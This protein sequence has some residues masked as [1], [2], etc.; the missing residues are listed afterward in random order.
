MG[1]IHAAAI[2]LAAGSGKRMQTEVPKQFLNLNG[3]PLLYYSLKIF[4]ESC[5]DRIVLVTG[6]DQIAYCRTEI[7]EKYGFHKIS[8]I[9]EG[10][11][12]RYDSAYAGLLAL[13]KDNP[14]YVLIHDGARPFV[15]Q[16]IIRRT[17]T[18]AEAHGACVAG[19]PVKD[20]I[21]LVDE[22]QFS[23]ATPDRKQ[24]WMMQTPQTFS[25]PLILSA[26]Q[27]LSMR[28]KPDHPKN[29]E[30]KTGTVEGCFTAD[31]AE[32]R[33]AT[34]YAEDC[35]AT[36]KTRCHSI[37]G[38]AECRSITDD[39]QVLEY[40]LD[41][42]AKIVEGSYENIKITTPSDLKIAEVLCNIH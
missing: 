37:L 42:R 29:E 30:I 21:R 1:K 6:E 25:Y 26:Y 40:M 12:E 27:K 14:E 18:G 24:V 3:H 36:E 5:V 38:D 20:T 34:D 15:T 28:K 4:E 31:H 16:D 10:G 8:A 19:M 23:T 33:C 17:L 7:V 41:R 13:E 11:K 39:A 35:F 32:N 9:V 22:E 2:V